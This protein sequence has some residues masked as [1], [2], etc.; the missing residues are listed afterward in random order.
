MRSL[1]IGLAAVIAALAGPA[2]AATVHF[3][4]KLD[5]ASE[6]PPNDSKGT[7]NAVV[8][9]DTATK[10]ITW[11]VTYSGLSGPAT[12]A[13]FHGPAPVGKAAGVAVPIVPAAPSPVTGGALLTDTQIGDLRGGLWYVNVHTA[14]HPGGEIRGQLKESH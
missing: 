9:L 13:H 6:T 14:A 3:T 5:G 8:N 1:T 2:L 12:M 7:G 10:K 11:K 4:A